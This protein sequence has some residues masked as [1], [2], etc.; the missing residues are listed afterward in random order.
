VKCFV[1]CVL[2][3]SVL[4]EVIRLKTLHTGRM[5]CWLYVRMYLL[6]SEQ[7]RRSVCACV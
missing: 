3:D 1:Q 2:C 7:L 6:G 4:E 5:L